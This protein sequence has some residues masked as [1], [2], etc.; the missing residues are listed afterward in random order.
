MTLPNRMSV[1]VLAFQRD[2]TSIVLPE[3]K[4]RVKAETLYFCSRNAI[5]ATR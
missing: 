1:D 3:L 4:M 5:I 2:M